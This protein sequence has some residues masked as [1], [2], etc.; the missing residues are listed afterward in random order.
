MSLYLLDAQTR[1]VL[2]YRNKKSII[3]LILHALSITTIDLAVSQCFGILMI[4]ACVL[5]DLTITLKFIKRV[6]QAIS[7]M[8]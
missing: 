5:N 4:L 1:I 8:H 6:F 2:F 3:S 7:D